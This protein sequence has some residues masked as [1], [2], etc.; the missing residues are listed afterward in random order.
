MINRK[1]VLAVIPA[2]GGSKRLPRK[3]MLDLTGKPLIAWSIESALESQYID[4]VVV[5]TDD[6]E[7]AAIS[8]QYGADVPFMRPSELA[9]DE[10]TSI[11]TVL[12]TI[13]T[14][15]SLGN[16]YDIMI[17]LQPTSP[18]RKVSDIDNSISQLDSSGDKSVV[19]VCE[20]EHSPLW[21]NMLPEDHSMNS[22]ISDEVINC[23]SQDLPVYYRLNGALYVV[24]INTLLTMRKPTLLLKEN[25]SAYIMPQERSIDIDTK[26]DLLYARFYINNASQKSSY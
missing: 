5:S 3:N 19:S 21:A 1:R 25:C 10:T 22:F 17:L 8:R 9:L 11:D 4:R 15:E 13:K 23:R 12:H 24:C 18:L 26:L 2:R 6:D 20:A 14:L 7:I 16:K